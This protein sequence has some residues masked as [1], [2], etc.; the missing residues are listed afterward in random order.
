MSR[1]GAEF[2]SRIIEE[3]RI[4]WHKKNPGNEGA[5]LEVHHI[6]PIA[7]GLKRGV[8]KRALKSQQNAVAVEKGFHKE[9]HQKLNEDDY[10]VLAQA[11]LAIWR[12]LF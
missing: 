8:P 4:N 11:L 10:N 3:E 2:S 1:K 12:K 9:V 6:L 5:E 7:E